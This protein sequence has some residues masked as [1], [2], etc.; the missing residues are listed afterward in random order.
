MSAAAQRRHR[1]INP[2]RH[3]SAP[4]C[5]RHRRRSSRYCRTH[6]RRARLYGHP[7]GG[8]IDRKLV[9]S[10]RQEFT[11]FIDRHADTPQVEAAVV[12]M[13]DS[14]QHGLPYRSDSGADFRLRHLRDEGV[15][16]KEAL[17]ILGGVWLL[18]YREPRALPDDVRLTYHLGLALIKARPYPQRLYKSPTAG[19]ML[20]RSMFPGSLARRAIG[21]FVRR[22]LGVFFMRCIEAMNAEDRQDQERVQTL[23]APFTTTITDGD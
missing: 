15:T 13:S 16:G 1:F 6:E 8:Q 11:D 19:K 17:E 20:S 23:A 7:L 5:T 3:C 22:R 12:L 9:A 10:Y 4:G 18:S 14:I 21:E 2:T